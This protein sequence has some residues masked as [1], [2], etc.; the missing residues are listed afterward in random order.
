[1]SSDPETV[2][3]TVATVDAKIDGLK[4]LQEAHYRDLS[5]QLEALHDLPVLVAQ[6]VTDYSALARRITKVE[7]RIDADE[8]RRLDRRHEDQVRSIE[9]RRGPLMASCVGAVV[10]LL[11]HFIAH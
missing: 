4:E 7:D 1:M 6:L 8:I 3:A 9:W 11:D 5:K 2:R 10:F